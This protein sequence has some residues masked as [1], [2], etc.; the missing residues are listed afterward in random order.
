MKRALKRHEEKHKRIFEKNISWL[1]A[2]MR[3][4]KEPTLANVIKEFK[5]K[6]AEVKKKQEKFDEE[7]DYGFRDGVKLNLNN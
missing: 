5:V 2:Q 3:N 4:V 6:W 1:A 7:S